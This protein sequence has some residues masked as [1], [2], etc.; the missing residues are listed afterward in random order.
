ME[1][2]RPIEWTEDRIYDLADKLLIWAKIP[3]SKYLERFCADNETYPQKLSEISKGEG[4]ANRY[5][6]EAHKI[7]RS[8]CAANLADATANGKVPCP[9]GIFGLKQHGWSDRL[10]IPVDE[11]TGEKAAQFIMVGGVELRVS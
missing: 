6:S 9:F 7:A 4:D 1:R 8:C 10:A 5:F 2:G 3:D 11:D